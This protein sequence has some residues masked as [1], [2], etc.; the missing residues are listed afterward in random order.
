[1]EN[2]PCDELSIKP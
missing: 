1:M 2:Q